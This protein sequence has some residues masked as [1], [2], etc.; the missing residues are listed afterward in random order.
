LEMRDWKARGHLKSHLGWLGNVAAN[1]PKERP[2]QTAERKTN[3]AHKRQAG[4]RP[5]NN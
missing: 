5:A 1:F 3:Y 4:L 2:K